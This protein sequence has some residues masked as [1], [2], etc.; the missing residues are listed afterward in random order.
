M[1]DYA[2]QCGA[3]CILDSK[4]VEAKFD[5]QHL[6]WTIQLDTRSQNQHFDWIIDASGSSQVMCELTGVV[7]RDKDLLAV[8]VSVQP[9]APAWRDH[10]SMN[11]GKRRA[12]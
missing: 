12:G 7:D 3:T 5:E 6:S 11:E 10:S 4:V 9:D 1:L 8:V 2:K